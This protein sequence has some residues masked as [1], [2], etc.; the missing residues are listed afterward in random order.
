[1]KLVITG[2]P[3]TGKTTLAAA[4]E[5]KGYKVRHTDDAID[6]GIHNDSQA[7]SE[8]F[9]EPGDWV[10]E[11][12]TAPRAI[13]KWIDQH[14]NQRLPADKVVFLRD[15]VTEWENK[16]TFTKGIETVWGQVQGS[17]SSASKADIEALLT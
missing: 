8:W 9:N 10:V 2:F 4:F 15:H 16:G 6:L 7:I 3:K 1:M 14:P 5:A 11:G 12:V 17:V 13:R